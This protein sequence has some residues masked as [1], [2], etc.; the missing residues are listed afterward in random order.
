MSNEP[1]AFPKSQPGK[2]M[3]PFALAESFTLSF[4]NY[5]GPILVGGYVLVSSH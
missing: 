5:N 2:H 3:I 4:C 1:E